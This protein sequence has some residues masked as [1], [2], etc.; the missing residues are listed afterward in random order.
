MGDAHCHQWI[1]AANLHQQG[2]NNPTKPAIKRTANSINKKQYG[3]PPQAG[4]A[5][6]LCL[7]W[8]PIAVYGFK[9]IRDLLR[10]PPVTGPR[11]PVWGCKYPVS[12]CQGISGG[13]PAGA[14]HK[15]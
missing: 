6:G 7:Q 10:G 9:T 4:F 8:F 11:V 1:Y 2:K 14:Y 13:K 15:P 5:A 3:H 12:R